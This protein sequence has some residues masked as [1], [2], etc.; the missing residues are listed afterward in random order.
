MMQAI[1]LRA[2]TTLLSKANVA[3]IHTSF[4][5]YCTAVRTMSHPAEVLIGGNEDEVR[6]E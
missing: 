4:R 1:V 3:C 6:V 2:V 5:E